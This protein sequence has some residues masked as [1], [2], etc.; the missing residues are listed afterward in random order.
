MARRKRD[1]D[2]GDDSDAAGSSDEDFDDFG[3]NADERDEQDLLSNPYGRKRRRR[4][5]GKDNATYGVFGEDSE[6]EGF[7]GRRKQPEKRSDWAKYV[8]S[9]GGSFGDAQ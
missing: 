6:D 7:G 9:N 4:A 2:D 8:L 1:L 5:N 3:L